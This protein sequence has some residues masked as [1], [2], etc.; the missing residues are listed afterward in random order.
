MKTAIKLLLACLL[1]SARSLHAGP[2]SITV[3]PA[4]ITNNY[5]GSIQLTISNLFAIGGKV[6]V[7]RFLDV[8][9]NGVVDGNEWAGQSFYV[10]D[11]QEPLIGGIRNSNVPG[12]DDGLT[13]GTMQTHVPY[14]TVNLTL[15]HVAGQYIYRVTDLGNSQTATALL[16]I[17][18]EVLPQG[19][20]GQVF[21]AGGTTTLPNAPVVL[22][23]QNGNNGY[24]TVSDGS[25]HFTIYAPPGDYGLICVYAGQIANG[26]GGVTIDSGAFATDD[27][28]NV[29]SDGT[30]ITGQVTD[31]VSAA[32]LP[33]IAVQAQTT[34]GLFVYIATGPNGDYS[35][36]VNRNN[37][38]VNLSQGEGTILGYCRGPVTKL[39]TNASSGSVAGVNFQLIKGNALV[40]GSVTTTQSNP[41]PSVSMR[42]S[43]TNNAIFDSE[44]LTDKNGNYSE[45][46]V[47][48][49]DDTG[50][51]GSDLT[52]YISPPIA[53]FTV[54]NGS[55]VQ[56]NFVLQAVSAYLSGVAKDNLGS[57][58]GNFNLIAD[59]TNDPS[60]AL[61]QSFQSAADGT[62]SEGLG[63][64]AWNLA[65]EC[66]AANSDSLISPQLT[67][68]L[69]NGE[70]L[71]NIVLVAQRA[72]A[73]IY[74]TV[75]DS[76]NNP[77]AFV[78]MFANATVDGTNYVSG[79][80]NTDTNGNYSILAFP[81]EWSV[82]ANVPGLPTKN[83]TVVGNNSVML[84][85]V[86]PSQSGPPSLGHPILGGGQFQFQVMGN[87]TQN[88]RID[89]S[90]NLLPNGWTPVFTNIGSFTFSNAIG[91]NRS[92][93]YRA[94]A[95]P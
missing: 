29:D 74:G 38:S 57:P 88:Y 3:S 33:G 9:S 6:R 27:V 64:G 59:P 32:G 40:Y 23:P 25:G 67:F 18:Q 82:G 62:F 39:T 81:A 30:T 72:T 50:L 86:A 58:L 87:G 5:V 37:W 78:S 77:L 19:A 21:N 89:V 11:G 51:N 80:V 7:D 46:V 54:N 92:R 45:A 22:V 42:A 55:A 76:S 10:T 12:D 83:V 61:D 63:T 36:S 65:L 49:G 53:F 84:N 48:G 8:N 44:G 4:V 68:N 20:T 85:F 91:T 31:S 41:V 95:V 71:S 34:N 43:D 79:C 16:Q 75:K 52:G 56:K 90:T 70:S 47:A 17:A 2:L 26:N 93:F 1:L 69:T 24:G 15:D 94:V 14:P 60:G 35:L 13:N 28:T 73:S 66:N